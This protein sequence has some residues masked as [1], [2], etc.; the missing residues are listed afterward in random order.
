VAANEEISRFVELEEINLFVEL[1]REAARQSNNGVAYE[2]SSRME[3]VD[4]EML[5]ASHKIL[6]QEIFNS[7]PVMREKDTP[8]D[9]EG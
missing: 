8:F 9:Q 1:I 2:W 3:G 6:S 5:V 4:R 7:I